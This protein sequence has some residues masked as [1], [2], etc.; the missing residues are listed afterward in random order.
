MRRLQGR[1][2]P[3]VLLLALGIALSS[4]ALASEFDSPG[5]YDGDEDDVGL[6]SK[7]LSQWADIPLDGYHLTF[8]PS[9]PMECPAPSDPIG[10]PHVAGTRSALA[11][12]RLATPALKS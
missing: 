4:A 5:R 9:A 3:V 7:T 8:I 12:P 10:P 11:L 1:V 2:I 6:I